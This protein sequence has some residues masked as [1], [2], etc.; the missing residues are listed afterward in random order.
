MKCHNHGSIEDMTQSNYLPK[1]EAKKHF[2]KHT[3]P[4]TKCPNHG[5]R[6]DMTLSN[7]LP[8]WEA[9]IFFRKHTRPCM[10]CHIHGSKQEMRRAQCL[11]K[12]E[13][14]K[15]FTT[16][17]GSCTVLQIW[18]PQKYYDAQTLTDSAYIHSSKYEI[19]SKHKM[20]RKP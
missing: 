6:E 14:K 4:C 9:K 12:W 1:W 20:D 18:R 7:C 10:K 17:M 15:N 19:I 5:S 8:K 2:R 16:C 11:S 3:R 13:A